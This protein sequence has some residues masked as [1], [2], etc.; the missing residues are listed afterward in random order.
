MCVG[1]GGGEPHYLL[2]LKIYDSNLMINS[3]LQ[4]RP[5]SISTIRLHN[6]GIEID[7]ISM[8]FPLESGARQIGC[9]PPKIFSIILELNAVR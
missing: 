5:Y 2:I 3:A 6:I 8:V 4:F 7:K 9:L 1:D